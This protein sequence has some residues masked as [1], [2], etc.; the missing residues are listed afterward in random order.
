M[1]VHVYPTHNQVPESEL[2]A[3]IIVI[4]DVLRATSVIATALAHGAKNI[5]TSASIEDALEAKSVNPELLL[6]GERDAQ[7]IPGFD[8]GNSPLEYTKEKIRDKR[9]LLCTSNGTKAVQKALGAETIIAA[10]FLNADAVV[11][12]LANKNKDIA[13]ICSGTNGH[14]S[15]DDGLCAGYIIHLL[16]K[17]KKPICSDFAELLTLPFEKENFSLSKLLKNAFHLNYLN[18]R[19]YRADVDYCL[20]INFLKNVPIWNKTGFVI[21][22]D[23]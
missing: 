15:L 13:I 3:P 18:S 6:G 8:L 19:G 10:S 7:K 12:Y 16:R 17:S 23:S 22:K 20:N 21:L 11:N 1:H 14:F 2:P 9:L 4:I 5:M